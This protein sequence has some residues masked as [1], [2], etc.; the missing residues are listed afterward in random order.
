MTKIN[1]DVSPAITAKRLIIEL[2][3]QGVRARKRRQIPMPKDYHAGKLTNWMTLV[4]LMNDSRVIDAAIDMITIVYKAK[5]RTK[6]Y[7]V[8]FGI[9]LLGCLRSPD[10]L[11][12]LGCV[13]GECNNELT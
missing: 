1:I 12:P 4:L 6:P 11:A 5:V 9:A 13:N 7:N 8:P 3:S 2:R 10:I